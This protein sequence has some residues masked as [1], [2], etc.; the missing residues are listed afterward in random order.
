M[1]HIGAQV[2][3]FNQMR[4]KDTLLL[5]GLAISNINA[6][7]HTVGRNNTPAS[8]GIVPLGHE[9][10]QISAGASHTCALLDNDEVKC[11]G[12]AGDG[13]IGYGNTE[14]IG[15]NETPDSVSVV[16]VFE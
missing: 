5:D 9:A 4:F 2:S 15:D 14:N 3:K 13:Q 6:M 1:T 10:V 11:W 16:I 12:L 8:V 7:G